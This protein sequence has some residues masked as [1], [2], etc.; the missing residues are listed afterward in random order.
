MAPQ[1]WVAFWKFPTLWIMESTT[2][3]HLR[4]YI[5]FIYWICVLEY[6]SG[7]HL[8]LLR[9]RRLCS[10]CKIKLLPIRT[11]HLLY[12]SGCNITCLSTIT[13]GNYI[14]L[15]EW[16]VL[17]ITHVNN[18]FQL[19][20]LHGKTLVCYVVSFLAVYLTLAILQIL[21]QNRTGICEQVGQYKQM[22]RTLFSIPYTK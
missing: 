22:S 8:S 5:I 13:K 11:I 10:N 4:C 2:I 1:W 6:F 19:L 20:N 16:I 18:I 15:F 3:L 9:Q 21:Q 7:I 14:T 12:I 17:L